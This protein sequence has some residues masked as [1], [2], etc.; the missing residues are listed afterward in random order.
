MCVI[1]RH[2]LIQN[3]HVLCISKGAGSEEVNSWRP[4]LN[5]GSLTLIK[6]LLLKLQ[7][8]PSQ[9]HHLCE[10]WVL[11]KLSMGGQLQKKLLLVLVSNL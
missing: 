11:G 6:V 9:V 4:D 8:F 10:I 3:S 5:P 2:P 7:Q 1:L